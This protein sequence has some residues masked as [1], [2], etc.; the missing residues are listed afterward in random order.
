VRQLVSS[1]KGLDQHIES[2]HMNDRRNQCPVCQ[3]NFFSYDALCNHLSVNHRDSPV[4]NTEQSPGK[5]SNK[6]MLIC[7]YCF[8]NDFD[9]LEVL[10]LHMQ[11]IHNV[12]SSEVYTCNYCNAPYH[13]LVQQL[14]RKTCHIS[15]SEQIVN[16]P[17]PACASIGEQSELMKNQTHDYTV[18]PAMHGYQVPMYTLLASF[19]QY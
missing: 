12:R 7:P 1:Q 16:F 17:Y 9:S 14:T 11:S 13:N 19:L 4:F 18:E 6:D 2:S 10:E 5:T 3:K 15:C 8:C